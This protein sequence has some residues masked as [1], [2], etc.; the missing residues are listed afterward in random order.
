[1]NSHQPDGT[2]AA[3]ELEFEA[4]AREQDPVLLEAAQWAVRADT[5][6]DNNG[7][8]R[9]H[10]WLAQDDRHAQAYAEMRR[11][12]ADL[13][14]PAVA[15][16][17]ARRVVRTTSSAA[18]TRSSPRWRSLHKLVPGLAI[19]SAC[20]ISVISG[21]L[22]WEQLSQRPMFERVYATQRGQQLQVWLP[23]GPSGASADASSL[24]LDTGTRL[25]ARLYRDRRDIVLHAGQALFSVQPDASRPFRVLAGGICITV[26]GTRFSVRRTDTGLHPGQTIVAVEE[27]R[28]RVSVETTDDQGQAAQHIASEL[29]A[30]QS[31]VVDSSGTAGPVRT[32]PVQQVAAWSGGRV[33][34]DQAPLAEVIAEFERYGS[35][36]LLVRDPN[37]AA[38]RVGGSF[39]VGKFQQF[40]HSLPQ[41]LPVRL[42]PRAG[43]TEVVAISKK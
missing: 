9:L 36:G 22:V 28:V 10:E 5:G 11:N 20:C 16:F 18:H 24:L 6:L 14:R 43:V 40:V 12:L 4:F 35:T 30:G 25:D 29:R 8:A 15:D 38:M 27:G 26:T 7:Q 33:N 19:A 39:E 31:I 34:F 42:V 41:V 13:R 37:V 1:M 3:E 32:L 17:G 23:D 21:W 2:P